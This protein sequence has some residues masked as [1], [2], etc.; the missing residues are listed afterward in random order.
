MSVK[1]KVSYEDKG[2][3]RFFLDLILPILHLFKVKHVEGTPYNHIY[4]T[5]KESRK[6]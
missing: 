2:E 4:L 1:I 3:A 5:Q 6:P